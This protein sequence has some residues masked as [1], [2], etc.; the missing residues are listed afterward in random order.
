M[1]GGGMSKEK[2]CVALD[3]DSLE[4]ATQIAKEI[5]DYVGIFKIG[6]QL[7]SSE[8]HEVVKAIKKIKGKIFLDLKYHDIPNTV[9][10][11]ARIITRMGISMFNI[12]TSGGYEMMA[13]TVEAVYGESERLK[14]NKPIILGVTVLTSIND[15]ILKNDLK[16][17]LSVPD[18]VLN[19]AKL[20]KRAGL[21][22]VVASP[23][24]TV[25]IRKALGEKFI[26][27]TPGIR[28][29]WATASD[30]QKRVTIPAEAIENGSDYI[31]IGR[32]IIKADNPLEAVK[33]VV[34]EIQ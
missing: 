11:A 27:L 12:H 17:N 14:I 18:Y 23:K 20:A 4:Q 16:I 33:K 25:L 29:L 15:L 9:A 30:D 28:P 8:G 31:V 3:V 10:N 1:L 2:I 32:P 34:A 6:S 26:I 24:E 5:K 13:R 7:Y 19:L 22:G 21:D